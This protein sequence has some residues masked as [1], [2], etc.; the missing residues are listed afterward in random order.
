MARTDAVTA[1]HTLDAP[2]PSLAHTL[3]WGFARVFSIV[4]LI[5]AWEGLARSGQFTPFVLPTSG[6]L[7]SRREVI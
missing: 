1:D 4:V 7:C 3:L 6:P 2:A 5:V